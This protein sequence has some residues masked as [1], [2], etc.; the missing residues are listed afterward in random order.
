MV[1]RTRTWLLLWWCVR[2]V[3]AADASRNGEGDCLDID[4]ERRLSPVKRAGLDQLGLRRRLN[5]SLLEGCCGAQLAPAKLVAIVCFAPRPH[6][7]VPAMCI[8][9][10][11]RAILFPCEP[12]RCNAQPS[13]V[14]GDTSQPTVLFT[15]I[16]L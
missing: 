14:H 5:A 6:V 10:S 13:V 3:C 7:F 1:A 15:S 12:W 4:G 16:R 11:P 9:R 2:C 8:C